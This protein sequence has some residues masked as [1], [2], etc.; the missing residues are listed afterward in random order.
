MEEKALNKKYIDFVDDLITQVEPLVPSDIN[1]LQIDY[2]LNNIKKSAITL[3]KSIEEEETF[4]NLD[5]DTQCMYIQIMAEWSFHKEI[6][7]FRSG[8]PAKYWKPVMVKIWANMWDV[9]FACAQNNA[10]KEVLLNV[11]EKYVTKAYT[12]AIEDLKKSNAIDEITEEKAKEQSN[13]SVMA[14]EMLD[15]EKQRNKIEYFFT[16]LFIFFGILLVVYLVIDRFGSNG[17]VLVLSTLAIYDV[18]RFSKK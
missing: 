4:Q 16:Y 11:I 5:F 8:I 10:S 17:V 15:G 2:L 3:A 14:K 18:I 6:D 9:M 13:I 1:K 7:L 12:N